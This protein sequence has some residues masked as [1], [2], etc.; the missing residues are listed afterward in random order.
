L[1]P[2]VSL[3]YQTRTQLPVRLVTVV[4]TD[5]R[6]NVALQENAIIISRDGSE[7]YRAVLATT[8]P[9]TGTLTAARKSK[10]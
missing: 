5:E 10:L 2:A 9:Q 6:C 8:K 3:I 4:L 1:Q 7:I